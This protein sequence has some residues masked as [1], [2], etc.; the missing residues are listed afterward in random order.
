M[1]GRNVKTRKKILSLLFVGLNKILLQNYFLQKAFISPQRSN[2]RKEGKQRL[3]KWEVG[4][5]R[6]T[7]HRNFSTSHLRTLHAFAVNY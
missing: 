3:R 7:H 5:M 1:S 2:E 4:K 6:K